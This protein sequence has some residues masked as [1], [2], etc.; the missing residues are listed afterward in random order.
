M[1][2]TITSKNQGNVNQ[3]G[4]FISIGV[5]K[6]QN[7]TVV[8]N[9]TQQNAKNLADKCN[10]CNAFDLSKDS[11]A[12]EAQLNQAGAGNNDET[13]VGS[14][15]KEMNTLKAKINPNK[16]Y[17]VVSIKQEGIIVAMIIESK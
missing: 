3:S 1:I 15:T 10:E 9:Y 2:E 5:A 12:K 11:D 7:G 17:K 8:Q 13:N 6:D 16:T 14:A 4:K